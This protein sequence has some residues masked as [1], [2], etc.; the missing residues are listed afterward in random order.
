ML[1]DAELGHDAPVSPVVKAYFDLVDKLP[2]IRFLPAFNTPLKFD[3]EAQ[4]KRQQQEPKHRE[5]TKMF[6]RTNKKLAG[7]VAKYNG[8]YARLC[9]LWHCIEH[10][11]DKWPTDIDAETAQRVV[12]FLHKFLLPH[13]EAFYESMTG[14]SDDHE[15]LLALGGYILTHKPEVLTNRD[16]VRSVRSMRGMTGRETLK[17]FEQLETFGWI[18]RVQQKLPGPPS[19]WRVNPAV[20][21]A[22]V[23]RAQKEA[24]RRQRERELFANIVKGPPADRKK[25]RR[26]S[27]IAAATVDGVETQCFRGFLAT[28]TAVDVC[29]GFCR[30]VSTKS[31]FFADLSTFVARAYDT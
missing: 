3:D 7:H 19:R 10:H 24:K 27:T 2:T 11:A 31:T 25:C 29:A 5:L 22:F 4:T 15:R 18:I 13:A 16:I 9:L 1:H 14:L 23:E 17:I 12:D 30:Q 20:H 21:T 8:I 28:P 26:L 6:Q